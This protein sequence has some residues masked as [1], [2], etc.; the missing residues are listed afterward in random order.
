M[1]YALQI[2]REKLKIMLICPKMISRKK[3]VEYNELLGPV[4]SRFGDGFAGKGQPCIMDE[5]KTI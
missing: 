4:E 1:Q 2:I 5:Q 3:V